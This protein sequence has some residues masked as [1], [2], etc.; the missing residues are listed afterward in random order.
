MDNVAGWGLVVASLVGFWLILPRPCR[1]IAPLA[2]G[3]LVLLAHH[4][5]GYINIVSGPLV[6]A[7][8]DAW[9]FHLFAMKFAN[10][11]EALEWAVGTSIYKSLLLILYDWF[12]KSQWLGQNLSIFCFAL[13]AAM[14]VR[15]AWRLNIKHMVT[16][17]LLIL[18]YGLTPSGLIYGTIMLREPIMTLAF[19][20]GSAL[21]LVALEQQSRLALMAAATCWL[22]MGL[23]HQVVLIF[24]LVASLIVIIGYFLWF[25]RV[26]GKGVEGRPGLPSGLIPLGLFGLAGAGIF[27]LIPSTGGDNYFDMLFDSIPRSI[28]LYRGA[29]ESSLPI[30][31]YATTFNFDNWL[32]TLGSL[33]VSYFYYLGWPVTGDYTWAGTWVLMVGAVLRIAGLVLVAVFRIRDYRIWILLGLY[34]GLTLLWNVGTTNHGQALRHHF[35]TDWVLILCWAMVLREW[36]AGRENRM[37]LSKQ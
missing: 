21:A 18:V 29:S 22:C 37:P 13:S 9:G 12:G 23:F 28:A 36:L 27:W 20:S 24:A 14:L 33:V 16:L 30:T 8:Y 35:M 6:F 4:V 5:L 15:I 31:G 32:N 2:A 7:K 25:G 3:A 26:S 19:I 34:F 17:A 11:P 10:D 1:Q